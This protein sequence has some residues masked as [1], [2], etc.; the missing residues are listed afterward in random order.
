MVVCVKGT[1]RRQADGAHCS[2]AFDVLLAHLAGLEAPP[3]DF[4][5]GNW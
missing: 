4:E 2:Y 3:P 1:T 5:D